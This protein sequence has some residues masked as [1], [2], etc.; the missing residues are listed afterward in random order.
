M[1]GDQEGSVGHSGD[2]RAQKESDGCR[3]GHDSTISSLCRG[4]RD[5]R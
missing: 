5:N 4:Q 1:M 3:I 2:R